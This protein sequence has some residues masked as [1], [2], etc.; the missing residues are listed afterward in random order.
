MAEFGV[1]DDIL[2]CGFLRYQL[3][4]SLLI[5]TLSTNSSE[6]LLV[7]GESIRG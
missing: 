4:F 2:P 1:F 7:P 5:C 3:I 6:V